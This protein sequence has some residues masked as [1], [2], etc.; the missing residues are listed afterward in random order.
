MTGSAGRVVG[1]SWY[2]PHKL[3]YAASLGEEWD[4]QVELAKKQLKKV[5]KFR[6]IAANK[7]EGAVERAGDVVEGAHSKA[8]QYLKDKWED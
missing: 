8:T 5:P 3:K 1:P 2:D 4:R 6:R 7:L